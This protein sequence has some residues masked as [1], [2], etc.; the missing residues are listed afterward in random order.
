MS[1][2]INRKS[3]L[4]TLLA[5]FLI[6]PSTAPELY[7]GQSTMPLRE[8]V[9]ALPEN[10]RFVL[11]RS[12]LPTNGRESVQ[13]PSITVVKNGQS[14]T[15]PEC[16]W[17]STSLRD[18][19]QAEQKIASERF[20]I[21]RVVKTIA[22]IIGLD[23]V[24]PAPFCAW[25][26][27]VDNQTFN[28]AFPD[29]NATYW[30]T[31]FL[32]DADTQLV[33][34]GTYGDMRYMSLAVYDQKFNYYEYSPEPNG[35]ASDATG[36]C[37]GSYIAD[38]QINPVEGDVNPFQNAAGTP[39][40]RYTVTITP[41]PQTTPGNV[42]PALSSR[43]G[44]L[45]GQSCNDPNG[46]PAI[47]AENNALNDHGG[48]FPAPCNSRR[49]PFT[50][51][52][53]GMFSSPP[54][55][56]Q[57]SVV[58]NPDNAYLPT[59]IDARNNVR[60]RDHQKPGKVFVVRGRLPRTPLGTSPVVWPNDNY[61]LRY[62]S[63]CSAVYAVPYPTVES[64][65]ACLADR[66]INRTNEAGQPDENGDWYTVIVSTRKAR[67]NIDYAAAGANWLE[68]TRLSRDILIVRNMLPAAGFAQAAQNAPR[69]GSWISAFRT[70]GDYYPAITVA[71]T[72]E[73][74]E[75][76]GWG[77]CVAPKI[78]DTAGPGTGTR[79]PGTPF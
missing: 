32:A 7:A 34:D 14:T 21:R 50:C 74:L 67:P 65:A 47:G 19:R 70:M 71:C 61:D 4:L 54:T 8:F 11:L 57:S 36:P 10:G 77:G 18:H 12:Y 46:E 1:R 52:L 43:S 55:A 45:P 59:W 35:C 33:I 49:S 69:D 40:D 78:E 23:P 76:N 66:D 73:H 72:K 42:L 30:A 25:W 56:I 28:I 24:G 48:L 62:W 29:S 13:L 68:A 26:F 63:I 51:A 60:R 17:R 6:L 75:Q 41:S 31:P 79:A 22:R 27:V 64:D 39:N 37:F 2:P 15:L 9:Q 58:S 16:P 38:Y 44:C 53:E 20:N 5:I 3:I